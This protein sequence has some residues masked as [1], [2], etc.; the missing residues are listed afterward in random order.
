MTASPAKSSVTL[1]TTD[2]H[3]STLHPIINLNDNP[4]PLNKKPKILGVTY[5][6]HLTFSPHIEQITS[7]TNRKMNTLCTLSQHNFSDRKH[8]LISV[9]KQLLRSTLNYASPAWYPALSNSNKTKLQ[10]TQNAALRTITGCLK[11]TPVQHLHDETKILPINVH[12]AMIGTQFYYKTRNPAHPCYQILTNHTPHRLK[13]PPSSPALYY[14]HQYNIIPPP[15][16]ANPLSHIHSVLTTTYLNS[17][18]NNKILNSPPPNISP[19]E[20]KLTRRA[21]VELARSRS[22][23]HPRLY[24]Y[25]FNFKLDN[26]TSP[27][28]NRCHQ[29]PDT[30]EHL[31]LRCNPL[32]Q[33][34]AQFNISSLLDLWSRPEE[35]AR[36]LEAAW[37]PI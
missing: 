9:Y 3:Q 27:T 28:C 24:Q 33:T 31:L 10:T 32:A 26:V 2:R 29:S 37:P 34:R 11:T 22:G 25:K 18:N 17:R 8:T 5:D 35:V 16:R 12:L 19:Q 6:T 4:I 30:I 36:F 15:M 1:L 21:Q 20:S 13:S 23:H 14:S 7:A